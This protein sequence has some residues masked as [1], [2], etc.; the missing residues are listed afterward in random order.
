MSVFDIAKLC[1][2]SLLMLACMDI[3]GPAPQAL[4]P[5]EIISELRISTRAVMMSLEDTL[6]L[7]IRAI[8]MD[9]SDLSVPLRNVVWRSSDSGQVYV[10]TL[11]N[12][13]PRQESEVPV[14]VTASYTHAGTTKSDTVSVYV[15]PSSLKATRVVIVPL[16]STQLG[17][18]SGFVEFLGGGGFSHIRIDLY[19]E[20]V[21]VL[22]GAQIPLVVPEQIR[23][24]YLAS[25]GPTGEPIY[26]VY[27]YGGI[28]KPFWIK[29]SVS[30]Y[31]SEIGDSTLFRGL[32]AADGVQIIISKEDG[33]FL[34]AEMLP[35]EPLVN[36]QPCGW[37]LIAV[38]PVVAS[39][40]ID[41]VFSDSSDADSDRCRPLPQHIEEYVEEVLGAPFAGVYTGGNMNEIS[42]SGSSLGMLGHLY[43]RRSSTV[44]RISWF[45]RDAVTKA[46]LPISG[47]YN[48]VLAE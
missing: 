7:S 37:V 44:G 8:A 3:K 30:L 24:F 16:D 19:D 20:N 29:V 41:I 9:G 12:L 2:L 48:Q 5:Y 38:H 43:L 1:G 31:G 27:N 46:R 26:Q 42:M 13:L 32:Y 18:Q 23:T 28:V 34:S 4:L 36:L 6:A 25:G 33:A 47:R 40:E 39:K 15:T 22:K 14:T 10:D 11:G 17:L 21:L 35:E 45:V